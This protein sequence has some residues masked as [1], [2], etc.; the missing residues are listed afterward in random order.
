[1]LGSPLSSNPTAVSKKKFQYSSQSPGAYSP[2]CKIR[3]ILSKYFAKF[4]SI[5]LNVLQMRREIMD[6][7]K[8][9]PAGRR[10]NGRCF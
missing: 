7:Q 6:L 2:P 8:P 4:D 10:N 3:K 9:P 5:I 1:M